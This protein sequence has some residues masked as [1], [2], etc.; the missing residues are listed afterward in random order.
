VIVAF[1]VPAIKYRNRSP[2]HALSD[3]ADQKREGSLTEKVVTALCLAFML[4]AVWFS[5]PMVGKGGRLSGEPG[6][7]AQLGH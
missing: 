1:H 6:R 5:G 7:V 4:W 3:G 2:C